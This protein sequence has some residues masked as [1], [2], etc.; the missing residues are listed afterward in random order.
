MPISLFSL[1]TPGLSQG[2]NSDAESP[3][4]AERR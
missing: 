4:N 1:A 3:Q 2:E